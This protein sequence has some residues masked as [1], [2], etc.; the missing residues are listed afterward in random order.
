MASVCHGPAIFANVINAATNEP[1][2]KGKTITG[3]TSEA[4]TTMGI[5]KELRR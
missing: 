3:F 1:L 5:M 4:E 2:I